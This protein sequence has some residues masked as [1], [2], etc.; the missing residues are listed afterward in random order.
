MVRALIEQ[1]NMVEITICRH[2]WDLHFI[3]KI[4]KVRDFGELLGRYHGS[5]CCNHNRIR[6]AAVP[7]RCMSS[8]LYRAESTNLRHDRTADLIRVHD[9]LHL[10]PHVIQSAYTCLSDIRRGSGG[11][12]P[13]AHGVNNKLSANTLAVGAAP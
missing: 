6:I 9:D 1:R 12:T 13:P 3:A 4:S 7:A 11:G 2:V 10:P 5:I 8:R